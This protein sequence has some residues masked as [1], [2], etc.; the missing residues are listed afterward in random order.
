MAD[1]DVK[2]NL[3]RKSYFCFVKITRYI[4]VFCLCVVFILPHDAIAH[5]FRL[6]ALIG[7]FLHHHHDHE[8]GVLAFVHDHYAGA[9]HSAEDQEEHD[10]LPFS[11]HQHNAECVQ[12]TILFYY[13]SSQSIKLDDTSTGSISFLNY[14]GSFCHEYF[15]SIWQPPKLG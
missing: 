2:S 8:T 7:H 12:T 6:P 9:G 1:S 10:Q 3:K 5:V 11:G 13:S 4:T 15:P 14:T